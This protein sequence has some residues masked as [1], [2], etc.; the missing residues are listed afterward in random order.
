MARA[1]A[2]FLCLLALSGAALAQRPSRKMLQVAVD[3]AAP[4]DAA[5]LA[6]AA[7]APLAAANGGGD[8][9][10]FGNPLVT[11]TLNVQRLSNAQVSV[12]VTITNNMRAHS[13][14][15]SSGLAALVFGDDTFGQAALN[16]GNFMAN[17]QPGDAPLACD[18]V[19]IT[20]TSGLLGLLDVKATV[21]G[22]AV[23]TA[24]G[25]ATP[26]PFPVTTKV[27]VPRS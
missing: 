24:T 16:C 6:D 15:P 3:G 5:P 25:I 9:D 20:K 14:V 13:F 8:F 18:P 11:L 27:D 4:A 22:Y 10:G 21:N 17:I 2:I 12:I 1:S 7:A 26:R 19:T 23:D